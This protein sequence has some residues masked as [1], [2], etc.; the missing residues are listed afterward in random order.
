MEASAPERPAWMPPIEARPDGSELPRPSG[1]RRLSPVAIAGVLL[2]LLMVAGIAGL[3]VAAHADASAPEAVARSFVDARA[4]G[5]AAAACRQ[6]TV[7][8]RRDMV[9][10]LRGVEPTAASASDCERFVLTTSERS[11]FTDPAL[12]QFQGRGMDVRYFPNREGAVI[13]AHGMPGEPFLEAR[14]VAGGWKLDGLASERAS[15]I[16]GC[17]DHGGRRPLCLCVFDRLAER[18]EASQEEF[19]S[20]GRELVYGAAQGCPGYPGTSQ[21]K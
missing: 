7:P 4:R 12:P 1:K 16:A 20:R 19:R 10:K 13:R 15:F 6:L 5:D 8:A 18:G 9:A 3:R 17:T 14:L 2:V 21:Q 11:V